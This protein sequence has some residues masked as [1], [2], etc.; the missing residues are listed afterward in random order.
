MKTNI[1]LSKHD[2]LQ[3][4]FKAEYPVDKNANKNEYSVDIYFFLPRNL[5]V[6]ELT[7]T[8][9]EFYNDFSEY[10]RFKTPEVPLS[11]LA[12]PDNQLW[13]KLD[14]PENTDLETGKKYIKMFFGVGYDI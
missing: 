8:S 12:T 4:E 10:I 5:A 14:N 11:R 13:H 9:R 7:Y 6:N 1:Q 2:Q 3:L